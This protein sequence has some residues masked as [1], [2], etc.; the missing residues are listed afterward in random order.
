MGADDDLLRLGTAADPTDIAKDFID[1]RGG[2][3]RIAPSFAIVAGFGERAQKVFAHPLTGNLDQSQIGNSG[4]PGAGLVG[5]HGIEQCVVHLIAILLPLHIDEVDDDDPADPAQFHLIGHFFRGL[6]IVPEN[7]LLLIALPHEPSGVDVDDGHRFGM[8]DHEMPAGLEPD[9][10]AKGP[11]HL[12]LD[13]QMIEEA[14]VLIVEMD[15]GRLL[16]R[17]PLHEIPDRLIL[18]ARVDPEPIDF[19]PE[20]I[21]HD[22]E[23]QTQVGMEQGRRPLLLAL[24]QDVLPEH[25]QKIDVGP[26]LVFLDP[27]AYRADNVAAAW[28]PHPLH[29]VL[30]PGSLLVTGDAAGYADVLHV[31]HKHEIPARERH[32]G[33]DPRT[34]RPDRPFGNLNHQ[35]LPFGQQLLDRLGALASGTHHVPVFIGILVILIHIDEGVARLGVQRQIRDVHEGRLFEADIHKGRLH[36]RQ[37]LR[38]FPLINIPDEVFVLR[39]IPEEIRDDSAV[40][41]RDASFLACDCNG[42]FYSHTNSF[43]SG[44]PSN[45]CA[46]RTRG[47]P[48][49]QPPLDTSSTD[50]FHH[51]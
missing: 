23:T 14:F 24:C 35:L 43:R 22:A 20:E 1:H 51:T 10:A 15:A 18:L 37:H 3:L 6:Q 49:F 38:H 29:N 30:E 2:R 47:I 26:Q 17:K 32:I 19:L 4:Y 7:G 13:A 12:L 50:G 40:Q 39:P 31:G 36:A 21:A 5:R 25:M 16:R 11:R 34:L 44:E 9:L 27:F 46:G 45:R 41:H 28:M 8:V 42:N 48:R 33:R